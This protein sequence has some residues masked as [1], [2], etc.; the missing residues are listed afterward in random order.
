MMCKFIKTTKPL[1]I[2]LQGTSGTGK[3]TLAALLGT[4]LAGLGNLGGTKSSSVTVMST[5]SIR[6]VMRNYISEEDEPILFAS[7]YQCGKVLENDPKYKEMDSVAKNLEGYKLQC[8]KVQEHL[9]SVIKNHM[10]NNKSLIVEGVH[11]NP[12]FIDKMLL[13]YP[14]QCIPFLICVKNPQNHQERFAVRSKTMSM[15]PAA[16][17]YIKNY[18]SIWEIQDMMI[19]IAEAHTKV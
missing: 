18:Q 19:K 6:H 13:T 1:L 3:S 17:K 12:P 11:L 7:T 8:E 14:G 2:L 10:A 16:N 4:R 5:D 9:S 15:D